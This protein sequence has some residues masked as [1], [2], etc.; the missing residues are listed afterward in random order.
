MVINCKYRKEGVKSRV[1]YKVVYIYTF[2]HYLCIFMQ[3][4]I[5]ENEAIASL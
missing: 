2:M 5:N 3:L 4:R 1:F